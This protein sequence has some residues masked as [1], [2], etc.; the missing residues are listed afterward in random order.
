[1]GYRLQFGARPPRFHSVINTVVQGEAAAVLREEINSLLNKRAIR[2]VPALETNKGWYSCYFV[3]PKKDGGRRPILDLRVLNKYLRTYKFKM[4][5]LRQ[6]LSAIRLGD[7]FTTINLTD[8]YFH[9]AIH[10]DHRQFL[11]FAFEGTDLRIPGAAVRLVTR[12]PNIHQMCRGGVSSA[13][14]ERCSHISLSGQL[15]YYCELQ[16]ASSGS[17]VTDPVAHPNT[18]LLSKSTEKLTD[19]ESAVFF[20]RVGN[21]LRFKPSTSVR[22]P[23]GHVSPLPRSISVGTKT[24]FPLGLLKMRAFQRWTHSHWLCVPRHL[25]RR[26]TITQSCM[27]ALLPWREPGL[28]QQGSLIG[29]V[30]CHK[31]VST[32]ASL[33]GW[34]A[35]CE[36][37]AVRGVWTPAQCRLHINHLELLATLL[38]LKHFRPVLTGLIRTDNTTVVSY[39]NKQGGTRSLPLLKLSHSLLLWCSAHFLSLRATHVPG[40]LNLGPHLPSR[41]GP[42]VREW[43]LHLLVVAQIWDRFGRAE[44]DLFASRANTHCPLFFSITDHNAPLGMD[45][46]AHTWPNTLLYAFPPSGN[47]FVCS[48]EGVPAG[49]LPDPGGSSWYAEIICLLVARPWQLPLRRDLLS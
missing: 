22:A 12:L 3:V 13:P 25:Q 42:L 45:A 7:W 34:G 33:R 4:L 27:S 30:S 37:A 19:P 18:G 20:P 9:V 24:A 43:R 48:G 39:I 49:A 47:D 41:G 8:A 2:V 32:D 44:V 26:L 17:A 1:M 36:G 40:H 5:T 21:M 38:A 31:V 29:R 15:G 16:G 46:L 11:R 23:G 14:G 10:L 6:L 28:L 35:L